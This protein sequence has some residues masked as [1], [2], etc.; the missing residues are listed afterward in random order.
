MRLRQRY[1]FFFFFP[2]DSKLKVENHRSRKTTLFLERKRG[3]TEPFGPTSK[4]EME[5][6]APVCEGPAQWL[7]WGWEEQQNTHTHTHTEALLHDNQNVSNCHTLRLTEKQ[8]EILSLWF[9]SGVSF[10][11]PLAGHSIVILRARAGGRLPGF[12]L[13]YLCLE[14]ITSLSS[15]R[16]KCA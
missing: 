11:W 1:F 12:L 5:D 15:F 9:T 3:D 6:T 8:K 10:R 13:C 2:C 4:Y 7:T 16:K 14:H